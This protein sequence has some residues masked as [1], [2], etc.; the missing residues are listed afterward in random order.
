MRI[1]NLRYI[2]CPSI[3][4]FHITQISGIGTC[5]YR[6]RIQVTTLIK[7]VLINHYISSDYSQE[8]AQKDITSLKNCS[9]SVFKYIN[10]GPIR[11]AK[12]A[13]KKYLKTTL[14]NG[15]A[16]ITEHPELPHVKIMI[17]NA[18]TSINI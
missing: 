3:D 17:Y 9:Y 16:K 18:S 1:K 8:Q 6:Y 11:P 2:V 12:I 14:F 5:R 13:G 4:S 7:L 10:D 15:K